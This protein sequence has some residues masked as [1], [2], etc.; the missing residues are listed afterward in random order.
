M[1]ARG[2][3]SHLVP[4]AGA[5]VSLG[6]PG[7]RVVASGVGPLREALGRHV[8]ADAEEAGDLVEMLAFL[9]RHASPF[10]RGIL[11]G[12]FTASAIVVSAAGDQVL[13]LHHRKLGRWLQPGDSVTIE[14]EKIGAGIGDGRAQQRLVVVVG[15]AHGEQGR[16]LR[17]DRR[18]QLGWTLRHQR[19]E[20]SVFAAFL[21][22][23]RDG[24]ARGPEAN[25]AVGGS[26]AMRLLA[27]KEQRHR[28]V[29]PKAK[30]EREAAEDAHHGVDDFDHFGSSPSTPWATS[31]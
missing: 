16:A 27:D 12:H 11:E 10:D 7:A 26:V 1:I 20:H 14:I 5:V 31:R 6:G 22:D 29:A 2:S 19:Q 24:A 28:A 13:L 21:G 4:A 3:R 15:H 25:G 23:A 9:D 8:P 18:I 17:N 30:I